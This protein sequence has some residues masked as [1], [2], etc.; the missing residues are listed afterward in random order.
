[1][2]YSDNAFVSM[3]SAML[4]PHWQIVTKILMSSLSVITSSLVS[5]IACHSFLTIYVPPK[6]SNLIITVLNDYY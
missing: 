3:I 1:M 6:Y 4:S 2:A 5:T